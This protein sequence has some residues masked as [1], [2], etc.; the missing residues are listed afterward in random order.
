M[1][2][3][4]SYAELK[5]AVEEYKPLLNLRKKDSSDGVPTKREISPSNT[6]V[7]DTNNNVTN[8]SNI[9]NS[10]SNNNDNYANNRRKVWQ[11]GK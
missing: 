7:I 11:N 1:K 5:A 10:A 4:N 3:I 8:I 2:R 9:A 6:P